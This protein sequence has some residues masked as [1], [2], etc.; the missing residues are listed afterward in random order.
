MNDVSVII[1]TYN[2]ERSILTCLMT[3]R[4]EG[5]VDIIVVDNNSHDTTRTILQGFHGIT[6][7][8]NDVNEGYTTAV[9]QGIR[10]ARG[11]LL[12]VLNPDVEI[13]A[14]TIH[15][16]VTEMQTNPMVGIIAP[17]LLYPD[18]RLQ[19]SC[20]RFPTPITFLLRGFGMTE[21]RSWMPRILH[22]HLMTDY[23]HREPRDVEWVLGACML[24]RRELVDAIGM[25]DEAYFLYYSD[26]DFC[27]RTVRSGWKVRYEPR[28][29]ATHQYGRASA[30]GGLMNP[31]T[32]SH[33]KSAVR[34]FWR[35]FTGAL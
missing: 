29:H 3:L 25:L 21:D 15:R 35:R 8:L 19:Y 28:I 26:I 17:K 10:H 4:Q 30:K 11:R 7:L 13:S 14:T 5:M 22:R 16:L 32:R 31:I 20:R 6:V 24:V 23:D 2:S 12:L 9:N 18:G 33:I 27:L 34:F 1:V